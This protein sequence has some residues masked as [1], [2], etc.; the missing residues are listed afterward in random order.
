MKAVIFDMDGVLIDSE[1]F[2]KLAELEVFSSL[3]VIVS[4]GDAQL[5]SSMTAEEVTQ[6]WFSKY[7]WES[8]SL[9]DV[10]KA[11]IS[12]VIRFVEDEGEANMGIAS[13]I[14]DLKSKGY[15]IGLATNSPERI[16]L[17]VLNKIGISGYF[18]VISSADF[19]EKGKPDPAIYLTT[20]KKLNI[21]PQN[22]FVIEDS[23]CGMVAAKKAGMTVVAYTN[24]SNSIDLSLADYVITDFS[25]KEFYSLF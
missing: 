16:I 23:F 5:T 20:S 4:E 1:P 3:G 19:E 6:Y 15:K 22:C 17:P 21:P 10:E 8:R 9:K 2:W 18:D 24:N 14:L 25:A 13:F 7:P 12:R 11:V